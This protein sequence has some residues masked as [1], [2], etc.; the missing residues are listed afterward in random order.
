MTVVAV[1]YL[2]GFAYDSETDVV[3]PTPTDSNAIQ[4]SN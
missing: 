1:G 3:L 4:D 2:E